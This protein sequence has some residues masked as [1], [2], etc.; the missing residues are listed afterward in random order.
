MP[1]LEAGEQHA[2]LEAK[3]HYSQWCLLHLRGAGVEQQGGGASRPWRMQPRMVDLQMDAGGAPQHCGAAVVHCG[4]GM[5][6]G[7]PHGA[8]L[9]PPAGVEGAAVGAVAAAAGSVLGDGEH[10]CAAP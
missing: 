10:A 9:V 4:R 6:G 7:D 1:M 5:D 2:A 8:A 3:Q